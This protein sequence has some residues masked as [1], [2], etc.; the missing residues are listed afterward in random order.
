[1]NWYYSTPRFFCN[2]C[3]QNSAGNKS[4]KKSDFP[5]ARV[6]YFRV[7]TIFMLSAVWPGRAGWQIQVTAQ[8]SSLLEK[9]KNKSQNCHTN[10]G[11]KSPDT[12]VMWWSI[13]Y[14]RL[15]SLGNV[16][17]CRAHIISIIVLKQNMMKKSST[18]ALWSRNKHG[19]KGWELL[20]QKN[21]IGHRF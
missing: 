3:C 15:P 14:H 21:V 2:Y 4:F 8:P 19:C 9:L 20:F 5:H 18:S 1:M 11:K 10:S 17:Q 13:G 16:V 6:L 7:C 12:L